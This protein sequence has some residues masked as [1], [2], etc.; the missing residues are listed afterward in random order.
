[1][2]NIVIATLNEQKHV[3][4]FMA[5]DSEARLETT[6]VECRKKG[7]S[8]K[9]MSENTAREYLKSEKPYLE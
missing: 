7:L 1:M 3:I 5:F 2:T 8:V 6:M 4:S 9:T